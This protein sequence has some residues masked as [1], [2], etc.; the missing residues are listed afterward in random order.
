VFDDASV[1]RLIGPARYAYDCDAL[2]KAIATPMW[3]LLD[4]GGKRWRPAL[5]ILI[6]EALGKDAATV[7][8]CVALVE[9][10]H[11]GTLGVD[12]VEDSSDLRRGAPCIHLVYGVDV[13]INASNAL[14]FFPLVNLR[15][16]KDLPA[17]TLIKLYETYGQEMMA[18]HVGQGMDIHWHSGKHEKEPTPDQYLQMVA[19]KTGCLARM[20]AKLAALTCGADD[21]TVKAF[22]WFASGIGV[23]FQIF[24]DLL[25][26]ESTEFAELKGRGEDIHEGKRTLIVLHAFDTA[27]PAKAKRLREILNSH[28]E[29][30]KVID[31]AIQICV[32]AGSLEYAR[33]KAK[34]I[35]KEAWA[36]LEPR[37]KESPAKAKL[38]AFAKYLIDRT[39]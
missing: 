26:L 39:I 11:Q 36:E 13:A 22:G 35:V 12:D 20:A 30:Q 32:D 18:V 33:A 10:A 2:T 7:M 16:R 9:L 6:A 23:A 24:D 19:N 21:E 29:D 1:S 17:E 3:D 34:S 5:L 27:P 25:S 14:Y 38:E 4:R 15:G 31:E 8:D 28:P 37:L